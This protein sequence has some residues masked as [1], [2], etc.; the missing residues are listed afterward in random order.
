MYAV[1]LLYVI[2]F[3]EVGNRN[4]EFYHFPPCR[5]I[6]ISLWIPYKLPLCCLQVPFFP[7]DI[8]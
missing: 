3:I 6:Q 4:L 5:L 2:E 1:S 7:L 8:A